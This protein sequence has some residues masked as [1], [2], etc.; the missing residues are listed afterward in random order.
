MDKSEAIAISKQYLQKLRIADLL[1]SEAWLF[2]SYARG[3]QHENSDIDLAIVL[4]EGVIHTFDTEVKLMKIRQGE[5]TR[6][7]PHAF[8]KSEFDFNIP[9]VHQI[10]KYGV[11][12]DI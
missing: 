4:H 10:I 3:S 11:R 6:I 5:E 9:I 12:L 8:T 7:E 2:G 1:F